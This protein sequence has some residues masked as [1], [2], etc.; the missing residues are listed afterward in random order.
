MFDWFFIT[1]LEV[2]NAIDDNEDVDDVNGSHHLEDPTS[3]EVAVEEAFLDRVLAWT[4]A[5]LFFSSERANFLP[6]ESQVNGFSPS[7]IIKH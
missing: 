7:K 4:L 1:T 6:Q 3:P 5:C 2:L